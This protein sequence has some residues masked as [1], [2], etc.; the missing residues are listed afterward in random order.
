MKYATI[1]LAIAA[2]FA[3]G[4]LWIGSAHRDRCMRAGNVGCTMLP[5]SGTSAEPLGRGLFNQPAQRSSGGLF[6]P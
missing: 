3:L 5:W 4:F 2:I 6:G 1:I